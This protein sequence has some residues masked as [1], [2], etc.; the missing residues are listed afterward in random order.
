M[1]DK[2]TSN[3]QLLKEFNEFKVQNAKEIAEVRGDIKLLTSE[4]KNLTEALSNSVKAQATK[5]DV[6]NYRTQAVT[7]HAAINARIKNLETWRDWATRLVIGS[8]ILA[9]LGLVINAKV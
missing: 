6:V 3:D 8:V 5:E 1:A 7:E 2:M 9:I 4:V